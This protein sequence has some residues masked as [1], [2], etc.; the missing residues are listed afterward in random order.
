MGKIFKRMRLKLERL[1]LS[2]AYRLAL[3]L[4]KVMKTDKF[5]A[6][7]LNGEDL[8]GP[9]DDVNPQGSYYVVNLTEANYLLSVNGGEQTYHIQPNLSHQSVAII[10]GKYVRTPEVADAERNGDIAIFKKFN[11]HA[12][13]QNRLE[14]QSRMK[15]T[16][17]KRQESLLGDPYQREQ[18]IA[19]GDAYDYRLSNHD[20]PRLYANLLNIVQH[21]E[22]IDKMVYG[23]NGKEDVYDKWKADFDNITGHDAPNVK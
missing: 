17:E 6:M 18:A 5:T 14:A 2:L 11:L 19:S 16:E 3:R 20:N 4:E 1:L 13:Q 22:Q 12:Y 9:D 10:P 8:L 23:G 15:S 21:V 7:D